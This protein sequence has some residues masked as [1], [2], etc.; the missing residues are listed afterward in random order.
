LTYSIVSFSVTCNIDGFD[1][2]ARSNSGSFTAQQKNIIR[3]AKRGG[4]VIIEDVRAR[5][6][7]GT[8]RKL[9]DIVLKLQ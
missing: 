9:N 2:T 4:R 8:V 1:E 5:G 7:D 6:P 3:K